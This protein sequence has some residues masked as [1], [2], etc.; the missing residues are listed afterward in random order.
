M[1]FWCFSSASKK[2]NQSKYNL[3][4][5]NI[6]V[7]QVREA[8]PELI[9]TTFYKGSVTLIHSMCCLETTFWAGGA[10]LILFH[11]KF[12]LARM[13]DECLTNHKETV[14]VTY[15]SFFHFVCRYSSSKAKSSCALIMQYS[16]SPGCLT[17]VLNLSLT[18]IILAVLHS[19][20]I[21]E[22][23]LYLILKTV[24]EVWPLSSLVV[25][26][27]VPP[28]VTKVTNRN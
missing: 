13:F 14:S 7:L 25:T 28:C 15:W 9:I 1:Y 22:T 12:Q 4:H 21:Q 2:N 17:L 11:F 16:I 10:L 24:L 23:Q 8:N 19:D 27:L 26:S 5:T 20:N 18:P 6:T 3:R